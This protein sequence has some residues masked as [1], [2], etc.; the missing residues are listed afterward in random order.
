MSYT[1]NTEKKAVAHA[2]RTL[3][4]ALKIPKFSAHEVRVNLCRPSS[5]GNWE[6]VKS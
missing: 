3:I 2:P 1:D 6:S 4:H 5:I